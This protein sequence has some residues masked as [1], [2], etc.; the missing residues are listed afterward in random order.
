MLMEVVTQTQPLL[1]VSL[2]TALVIG[3]L[4]SAGVG[5]ASAAGAFGGAGGGEAPDRGDAEVE[6]ARRRALQRSQRGV[7]ARKTRLTGSDAGDP[8]VSRTLLLGGS[9]Q[10]AGGPQPLAGRF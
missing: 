4:V 10:L 8:L 7:S 2:A 5:A 9:G 3:S 1:A 6:D